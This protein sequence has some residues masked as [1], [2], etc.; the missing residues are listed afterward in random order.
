MGDSPFM[1]L[2]FAFFMGI[3]FII[4]GM[5]NYSFIRWG[6]LIVGIVMAVPSGIL[7]F[8]GVFFGMVRGIKPADRS[9]EEEAL[10]EEGSP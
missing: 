7:L 2:V 6:F 3:I 9:E 5:E 10:L 4:V 1:G 8:L